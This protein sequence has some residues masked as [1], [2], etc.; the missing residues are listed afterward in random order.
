MIKSID[1]ESAINTRRSTRSFQIMPI[2]SAKMDMMNNFISNMKMPFVHNVKI[3]MF[4]AAPDKKL[5]T[6]FSAPPDNMAFIANTDVCSISAAGFVG[7]VLILYATSIGL[8]TCWYG[9][10]T[11]SELESV[12]PHLGEYK[13]SQNPK[14]GYG[15]G[16]VEGERTICITPLAYGNQSGVRFFDRV[17]ENLISY[18]RKPIENFLDGD[19]KENELSPVLLYALDLARKAPSAANS[20]HWRFLISSDQKTI[21]ISMPIDY[22]HIKWEHPNV[23]IGICASHFWLGLIMK[24]IDCTVS[25]SEDK[26]RAIW[27]FNIKNS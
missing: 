19:V 6:I 17:Q 24:N 21:T 13:N 15:K 16:E 11:L 1:W 23:D 14:W 18:K 26:G 8:S 9:H 10:Y 2:E 25:L 12:M 27:V 5:Y 3:K 4:K 20:Q 22:K 7:E